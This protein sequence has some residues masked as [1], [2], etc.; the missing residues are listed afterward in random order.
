MTHEAA[1]SDV[2]SSND[3]SSGRRKLLSTPMP[4]SSAPLY[5]LSGA[6]EVHQGACSKPPG[7][8]GMEGG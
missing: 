1:F 2:S 5:Y 8:Q 4:S 7:L 3:E 6:G